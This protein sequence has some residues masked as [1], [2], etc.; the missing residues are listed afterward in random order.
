MRFDF[1]NYSSEF[2]IPKHSIAVISSSSNFILQTLFKNQDA[3]PNSTSKKIELAKTWFLTAPK[4][5][6]K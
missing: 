1:L 6:P 5:N 3:I 2:A 4:Q